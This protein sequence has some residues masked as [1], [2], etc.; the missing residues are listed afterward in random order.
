MNKLVKSLSNPEMLEITKKRIRMIEGGTKEIKKVGN[1][2][3]NSRVEMMIKI[4]RNIIK[5]MIRK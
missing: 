4:F 1:L 5:K 3:N 2:K